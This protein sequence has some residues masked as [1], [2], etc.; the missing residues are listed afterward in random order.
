[1]QLDAVIPAG[2]DPA[3]DAEL[4]AYAG[5]AP[6]KALIKLGDKT[7]LERV[8]SAL[9][10]S[11]CVRRI[12]VVGLPVAYQTNLGPE[13]GFAPDA[14]SMLQ[15]G[16][17]G[18][19]Y[20]RSTGELSERILSATADTPLITP[21]I[22]R[23]LVEQHLQ[24]DVDFCYSIVRQETMERAFPGSGRTFVPIGGDRFAGGDVNVVSPQVLDGDRTKIDEIVGER[25]T[26]WK[27]VHAIGLDTLFFFLIRR[28]TIAKLE[29]RV[30]RVLGFSAKAVICPHAEVAMD[31]D[32]PHHLDVVRA[33]WQRRQQTAPQG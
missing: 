4:L 12:V 23:D 13:V 14:G 3:R 24:Y 9:Q 10:G 27:Q 5:G 15:N 20:L 28:L 32:K 19:D 17:A 29:K 21:A 6:C 31:V 11:G 30:E 2:G 18:L 25:K 16:E 22:I 33:A 1:M 8:V 7:F 26:F